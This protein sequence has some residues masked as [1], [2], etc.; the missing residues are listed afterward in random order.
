MMKLPFSWMPGSWGLNGQSKLIAKAEYELTGW[1]LVSK[2]IEIKYADDP[3]AFAVE[4]LKAKLKHGITNEY[5]YL[6]GIADLTL[7][8]LELELRKLEI[9]Y[10]HQK[11]DDDEYSKMV[12][13]AK[14]E[15]YIAVV[16]SSYDPKQKLDGFEF[17]FDW[18][19]IWLELLIECGYTGA[20]EEKII[21]SWFTDLCRSVLVENADREPLPFNTRRVV[22]RTPTQNGGSTDYS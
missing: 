3:K 9:N 15:P 11:L 14:N 12:A 21:Q 7:T 20:T 13:T 17:E 2:I 22:T 19:H 5:D 6:M 1:D 18:N 10:K 8:G 16:N 4:M